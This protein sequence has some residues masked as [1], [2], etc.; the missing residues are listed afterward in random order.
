MGLE[1][2]VWKLSPVARSSET[3]LMALY[4]ISKASCLA[5]LCAHSCV[6]TSWLL[7]TVEDKKPKSVFIIAKCLFLSK[8]PVLTFVSSSY[9]QRSG[10]VGQNLGGNEDT[11]LS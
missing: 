3:A 10:E 1:L 2:S 9:L 7:E 8:M 6:G 11:E 4:L 5:S